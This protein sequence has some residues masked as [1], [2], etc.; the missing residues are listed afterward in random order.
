MKV[1]ACVCVCVCVCMCESA[2]LRHAK[3]CLEGRRARRSV[4]YMLYILV[5]TVLCDMQQANLVASPGNGQLGMRVKVHLPPHEDQ[6]TRNEDDTLVQLPF[7]LLHEF[8]FSHHTKKHSVS[9][10]EHT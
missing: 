9:D 7:E 6:E 2:L 10:Q 4:L 1:H 5:A 8:L 3:R